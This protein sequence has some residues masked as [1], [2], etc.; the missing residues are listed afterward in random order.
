MTSISSRL[1]PPFLL[2]R[3]LLSL[4][5]LL[6]PTH[7]ACPNACSQHGLCDFYD[8][9]N[10]FRGFT[11]GDCSER[12]CP[13]GYSFVT[14]PQG[15]L[16]MDGDRDDNSWRRLSLPIRTFKVGDSTMTMRS[17]FDRVEV[18]YG[19]LLKVRDQI[20]EVQWSCTY[21]VTNGSDCLSST[22]A[23]EG[24]NN[25]L[26]FS[27]FSV[28]DGGR[29]RRSLLGVMAA[30]DDEGQ[31][32]PDIQIDPMC[33]SC[34]RQIDYPNT[35][36]GDRWTEITV[37]DRMEGLLHG[38]VGLWAE[39]EEELLT[40]QEREKRRSKPV[41][42][43]NGYVVSKYL[44]TQ[45]SPYGTWEKWPG[46]FFGAGIETEDEGHFYMECSNRGICNRDMGLCECHDGYTGHACRLQQCPGT[47]DGGASKENPFSVG[48]ACSGRG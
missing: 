40:E 2:S 39:E 22:T 13:T 7:S 21:V 29:R 1:S 6:N 9:C 14:T 28:V 42:I 45:R 17:A 11:G 35:L 4:L 46:N 38:F 32:N 15:D 8:M 30:Y 16:N 5:L 10:C 44:R 33:R 18:D 43:L 31:T 20:Y 24:I 47:S 23:A 26:N 37:E 27:D 12:M 48:N 19:D 25:G 41:T 34:T 36:M 3:L